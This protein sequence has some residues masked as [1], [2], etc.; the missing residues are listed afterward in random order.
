MIIDSNNEKRKEA[1]IASFLGRIKMELVVALC[2]VVVL[3]Q[4]LAK[5]TKPESLKGL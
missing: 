4:N 2:A 1:S 3:E 5:N